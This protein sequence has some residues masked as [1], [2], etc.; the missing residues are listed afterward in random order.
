[1]SNH[2]VI[3]DIT[4]FAYAN[5]SAVSDVGGVIVD[6]YN[7]LGEIDRALV[8]SVATA[9]GNNVSINVGPIAE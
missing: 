4:Q 2:V 9:V 6:N 1:L 7:S 8:S 3:A 5:V